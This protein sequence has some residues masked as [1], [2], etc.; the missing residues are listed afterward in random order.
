MGV[1][2][3]FWIVGRSS[4]ALELRRTPVTGGSVVITGAKWF[5]ISPDGSSVLYRADQDS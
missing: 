1:S 4:I 3:T 5:E 2:P